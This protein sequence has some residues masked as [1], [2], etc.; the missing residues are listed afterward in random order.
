MIQQRSVDEAVYRLCIGET[1]RRYSITNMTRNS[2]LRSVVVVI[3]SNVV[4]VDV[5]V[6]DSTFIFD[7]VFYADL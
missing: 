2:K 5:V 6:M 3:V 4:F 1:F 7:V